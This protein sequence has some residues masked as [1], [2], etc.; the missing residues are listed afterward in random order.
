MVHDL[1][2][3]ELIEELGQ[4]LVLVAKEEADKQQHL[5]QQHMQQQHMQ[6]QQHNH[7]DAAAEGTN[8]LL[9]VKHE[10]LNGVSQAASAADGVLQEAVGQ[11]NHSSSPPDAAVNLAPVKAETSPDTDGDTAMQDM[12]EPDLHQV[13][14]SDAADGTVTVTD[15]YEAVSDAYAAQE[16]VVLQEFNAI[17]ERIVAQAEKKSSSLAAAAATAPSSAATT[18]THVQQIATVASTASADAVEQQ[19]QQQ[20]QQQHQQAQLPQGQPQPAQVQ[21]P[22]LQQQFLQQQQVQQTRP[23]VSISLV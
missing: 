13:Q 3:P 7:P 1:V 9:K 14:Q 19:A 17:L 2:K 12:L 4:L 22:V 23:L 15:A 8:G 10:L 11:R 18:P 21:Q 5:Q 6:Q 16:A 20:E